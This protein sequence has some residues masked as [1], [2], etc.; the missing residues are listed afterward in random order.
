[1]ATARHLVAILDVDVTARRWQQ[2]AL[3]DIVQAVAD[4]AGQT[5]DLRQVEIVEIVALDGLALLVDEILDE[6]VHAGRVAE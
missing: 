2:R 3:V 1:M 4:R 5:I 6:A